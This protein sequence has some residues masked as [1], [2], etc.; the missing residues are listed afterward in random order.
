[1]GLRTRRNLKKWAKSFRRQINDYVY[2]KGNGNQAQTWPLIRCVSLQGPWGV[3]SS[4]G[5]LVDLPG[6]R[7]ANAARARVSERYLQNC[8]Q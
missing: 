8:N 3:L 6:V 1:M 5:V 4:G 7:D 2:R